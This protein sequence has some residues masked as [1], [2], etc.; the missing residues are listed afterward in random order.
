MAL[1]RL[2][3]VLKPEAAG[4]LLV[5]RH[6]VA[7]DEARHAAHTTQP[8][9]RGSAGQPEIRS[10]VGGAKHFKADV[11]EMLCCYLQF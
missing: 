5:G 11:D 8:L 4:A 1:N 3:L 9:Q 6:T 2:L 10:W 7:G